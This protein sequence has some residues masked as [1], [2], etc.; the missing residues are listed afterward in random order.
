MADSTSNSTPTSTS[1]ASHHSEVSA[2]Q[3][4]VSLYDWWLVKAKNDFQGKRLAVAGVS[5]KKEEA[6]R[7]FVSAPVVKRYDV[8]SLET[9]DRIYVIINGFINEQRTLEN[10]FTPE[11]FNH[12]LFGF[13]PNWESCALDCFREESTTDIDLDSAVPDEEL[14]SHP[15]ILPDGMEKS[16][17]TLVSPEETLGDHEQPFH[18]DECNVSKEMGGSNVT[19]GSG[20]SRR[21]TRLHNIKVCQQKKQLASGGAPEHPDK[22]QNSTSVPLENCDVE[23]LRSPP[24]PIHSQSQRQVNTLSEQLVK[25]PVSRIS[26][27]LSAK[28]DSCSKKKRVTVERKVDRPKKKLTRSAT[29][30]KNRQE[31]DV[32]H[33]FQGSNQ[34]ISSVSPA[35]LSF[36]KSRSGRL[37]LPPLEFWRNQIPVYNADHEI[38]EIQEGASLV[39]PLRGSSASMSR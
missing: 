13:P 14:P 25:K 30:V 7:V 9:A 5:S 29:A 31:K 15:E 4:T 37:L 33:L 16:V 17:P 24:T 10:G 23:G 3:R 34:K 28:T 36:R 6:M 20:G 35:S 32:S 38:T 21:S 12:F 11:V 19:Y 1:T 18:E 8:F 27:T 39:S 2:F 26:R 22:E